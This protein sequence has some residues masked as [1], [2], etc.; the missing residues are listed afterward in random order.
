[1]ALGNPPDSS[2]ESNYDECDYDVIV[3][4]LLHFHL[5]QGTKVLLARLVKT[6][7]KKLRI[8]IANTNK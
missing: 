3:Y 1:M 4:D 5:S 7:K 6:A 8:R 2:S